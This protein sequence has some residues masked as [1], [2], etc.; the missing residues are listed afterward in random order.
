MNYKC[1]ECGNKGPLRRMVV[2]AKV[3]N[4]AKPRVIPGKVVVEALVCGHCILRELTKEAQEMGLY[5]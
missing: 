4:W 2:P 5:E 1:L 3:G